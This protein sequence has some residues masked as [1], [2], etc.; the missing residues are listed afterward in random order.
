MLSPANMTAPNILEKIYSLQRF[1]L[2]I[3]Y[4]F[5]PCI[6]IFVKHGIGRTMI[7]SHTNYTSLTVFCSVFYTK[8]IY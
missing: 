8:T 4:F 5:L 6:E 7:V 2:H 3:S 1:P